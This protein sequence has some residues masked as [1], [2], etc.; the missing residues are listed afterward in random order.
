MFAVAPPP[1]V[2]LMYEIQQ[3]NSQ[4]VSIVLTWSQP[5]TDDSNAVDDY[6]VTL[7]SSRDSE[8]TTESTAITL[9]LSYNTNYT[10]QAKARNCVGIS[11]GTFLGLLFFGKL[12]S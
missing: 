7:M 4:T 1:P 5:T 11:I 10:V 12:I 2:G 8:V 3:Q 9:I 6:I